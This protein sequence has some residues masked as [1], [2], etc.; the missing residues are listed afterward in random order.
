MAKA[1]PK[2]VGK[3]VTVIGV[4]HRKN[5]SRRYSNRYTRYWITTVLIT[6]GGELCTETFDGKWTLEQCKSWHKKIYTED[7]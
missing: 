6:V 1:K 4:E 5:I 2:I 3:E 7:C